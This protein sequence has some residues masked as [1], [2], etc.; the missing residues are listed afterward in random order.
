MS[1]EAGLVNPSRSFMNSDFGGEHVKMQKNGFIQTTA[2]DI[3]T[4]EEHEGMAWA[5][6]AL[7]RHLMKTIPEDCDYFRDCSTQ[8]AKLK[9]ISDGVEIGLCTCLWLN[10]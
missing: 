5:R 1:S 6:I 4:K 10:S 9:K 2:T 3:E 8:D 7:S